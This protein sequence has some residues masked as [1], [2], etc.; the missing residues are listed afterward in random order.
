MVY[1]FAKPEIAAAFVLAHELAHVALRQ[2][3]VVV[4]NTEAVTNA[5]AVHWC[6]EIG[7]TVKVAPA[8]G[9]RIVP[10]AVVLQLD[11]PRQGWL[12]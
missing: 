6:S 2:K 8:E 5:L 11:R 12:W 7:L 1:G 10:P 4:K 3:W 9:G